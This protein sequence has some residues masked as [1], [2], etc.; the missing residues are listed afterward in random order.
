MKRYILFSVIALLPLRVI[1]EEDGQK[2]ALDIA[3]ESIRSVDISKEDN[4]DYFQETL[5][6]CEKDE[7]S[8]AA[9]YEVTNLHYKALLQALLIECKNIEGEKISNE[10]KAIKILTLLKKGEILLKYQNRSKGQ[11]LRGLLLHHPSP[12]SASGASPK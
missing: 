5:K 7:N 12:G 6:L 10:E 2:K 1:S 11:Y 9:T 4:P 3:E 8:S